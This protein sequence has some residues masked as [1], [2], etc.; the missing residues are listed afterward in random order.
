MA[1]KK[2]S[3]KRFSRM[4]TIIVAILLVV[5]IVGGFYFLSVFIKNNNREQYEG[6]FVNDAKINLEAKQI[7]SEFPKDFP[8]FANSSLIS[9]WTNEDKNNLGISVVWTSVEPFE[10]LVNFYKTELEKNGY[11]ILTEF[12]NKP[13]Y[14]ISFMKDKVSG[15]I[16]I[17]QADKTTISVTIGFDK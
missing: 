17:A 15:Y 6:E 1:S 3:P 9:A 7:P 5:I 12:N 11:K 13:S 8:V 16:G 2:N 10:T 14:T 4:A